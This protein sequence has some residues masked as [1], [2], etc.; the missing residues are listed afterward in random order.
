M[1]VEE[2]LDAPAAGG[3]NA[4]IDCDCLLQVRGG[5]AGVAVVEMAAA[6]SFQ[7]AGFL[8]GYTNVTGDG[9]CVAVAVPGLVRG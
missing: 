5:L 8:E 4:L 7:S 9:Q 6:D 3:S 2:L 1:V